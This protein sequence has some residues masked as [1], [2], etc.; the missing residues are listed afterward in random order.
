MDRGKGYLRRGKWIGDERFVSL[1]KSHDMV[2]WSDVFGLGTG[3]LGRLVNMSCSYFR[4]G[5]L[6]LY[7][8]GRANFYP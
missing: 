1:G 3:V 4:I 5:Y 6:E 8:L 2:R 7:P